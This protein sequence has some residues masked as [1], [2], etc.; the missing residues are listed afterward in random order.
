MICI[1]INTPK[2][3]LSHLCNVTCMHVLRADNLEKLVNHFIILKMGTKCSF[4][5]FIFSELS[6]TN[7]EGEE[8]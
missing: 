8:M 7:D 3:N 5:S 1:Y 2:Y 6:K 4:V